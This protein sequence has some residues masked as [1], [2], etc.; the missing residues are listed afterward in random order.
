MLTF[1]FIFL[2]LSASQKA[3]RAESVS[4]ISV[5][6]YS[7]NIFLFCFS[8]EKHPGYITEKRFP[9]D[10]KCFHFHSVL[11]LKC[12]LYNNSSSWSVKLFGGAHICCQ[13]QTI[14]HKAALTHRSR[15]R[16][17]LRIHNFHKVPP[18]LSRN[19]VL[20]LAQCFSAAL[21]RWNEL[22]PE[23]VGAEVLQIKEQ[24]WLRSSAVR[25]LC[26]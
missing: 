23:Y 6:Y 3:R 18:F 5:V 1:I 9:R 21:R 12:S 10:K 16:S 11:P 24:P 8:N 25:Q 22:R 13:C 20:H 26:K 14:C 2:I 15:L 17:L 7:Q 4:L 19:N